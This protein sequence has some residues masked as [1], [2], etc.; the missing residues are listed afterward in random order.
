VRSSVPRGRRPLTQRGHGADLQPA[1]QV[2]SRY[3]HQFRLCLD[4]R[5]D[6][7]VQRQASTIDPLARSHD[8]SIDRRRTH[9]PQT[10]PDAARSGL[11]D[12]VTRT[13]LLVTVLIAAVAACSSTPVSPTPDADHV[14]DL[15]PEG[16]RAARVLITSRWCSMRMTVCP[17]STSVFSDASSRSISARCSPVVG[18]SRMYTV[19]FDFCSVLSSGDLHPLR[20]APDSAVAD[21]PSVRYPRSSST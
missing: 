13:A 11:I 6:G 18:S 19:C 8:R 1:F 21:W 10:L 9:G 20:L 2:R 5:G 16:G 12:Q 3:L 14:V 15:G 17:A 4:R 7:L